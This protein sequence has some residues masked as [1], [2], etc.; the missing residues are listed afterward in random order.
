VSAVCDGQVNKQFGRGDVQAHPELVAAV[1]TELVVTRLKLAADLP[2]LQHKFELVINAETARLLG[3][4]VPPG[5]LVAAD[6][7]IE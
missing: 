1:M 2:V 3:L 6:E 4:A 7:V 5:L